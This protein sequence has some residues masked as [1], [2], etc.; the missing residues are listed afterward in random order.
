MS[1][2]K[3]I[4][5]VIGNIKIYEKSIIINE[6][7]IYIN[8][9]VTLIAIANIIKT[10]INDSYEKGRTDLKRDFKNLLRRSEEHTSELHHTDISRMPSSA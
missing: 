3:E 7:A 5:T 2:K 4:K 10:I 1:A 6:H 8:H 9:D